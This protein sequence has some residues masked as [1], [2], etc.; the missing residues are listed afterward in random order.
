MSARLWIGI[1]ATPDFGA[2]KTSVDFDN[3]RRSATAA[4]GTVACPANILGQDGMSRITLLDGG[5]DLNQTGLTMGQSAVRC[6]IASDHVRLRC[7]M[8]VA[9]FALDEDR[10][11]LLYHAVVIMD[12]VTPGQML[13]SG[14][15][16]VI[17][18]ALRLQLLP[19]ATM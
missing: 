11:C 16:A 6:R 9:M 17:G 2:R 8:H 14:F 1:T 12:T 7:R 13:N 19:A 4:A 5:E 15:E 10:A 18:D 3:A